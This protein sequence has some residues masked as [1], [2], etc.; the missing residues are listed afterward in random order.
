MGEEPLGSASSGTPDPASAPGAP[1]STQ[2]GGT[3][4]AVIWTF[5]VVAVL[6]LILLVIFMVQNQDRVNVYF[7]G[8]HG[9]LALGVAMLIAAVGG[10]VV[11]SIVGAV[12]I[13]QLRARAR[14]ANKARTKNGP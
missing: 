10:A 2:T 6:V 8:F 12:R 3:R 5:T 9:Q 13:I 7:L 11:V 14:T 4:A 1:A